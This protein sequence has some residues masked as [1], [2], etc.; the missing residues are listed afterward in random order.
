M[1]DTRERASVFVG[2]CA[3]HLADGVVAPPGRAKYRGAPA[4]AQGSVMVR[5]IRIDSLLRWSSFLERTPLPRHYVHVEGPRGYF[6]GTL[7]ARGW[8]CPRYLWG[9]SLPMGLRYNL[10]KYMAESYRRHHH[11]TTLKGVNIREV[12]PAACGVAL[13]S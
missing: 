11:S 7:P 12:L 9:Y 10:V 6:A 1:R 2:F 4:G 8:L 13:P 3:S 5:S